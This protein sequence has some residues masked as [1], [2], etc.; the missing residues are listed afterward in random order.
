MGKHR[1]A[2]LLLADA[3]KEVERLKVKALHEQ[4]NQAPAVKSLVHEKDS[5]NKEIIK[6]RRQLG[7]SDESKGYDATIHRLNFQIKETIAQ[8][9]KAES[10]LPEVEER[11]ASISGELTEVKAALVAD[12]EA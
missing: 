2:D 7:I 1:P 12:M 8:K 10:R 5:L 11:L 4:L 3:M 6:L 9:E